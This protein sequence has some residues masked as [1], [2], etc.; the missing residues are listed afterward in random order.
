[1]RFASVPFVASAGLSNLNLTINGTA[2]TIA[3]N[4]SGAL[5]STPALPTGVSIVST[6]TSSAEGRVVIEYDPA[7]NTV[8]FNQPQDA[9]GMKTADLQLK[10]ENDRI[11]V[12]SLSGE[13]INVTATANSLNS[14]SIS[15]NDTAVEDLLVLPQGWGQDLLAECMTI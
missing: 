13:V 1:M 14:Q 4:S 7:V 5:A 10:L 15:I 6:V 11:S 9:L 2:H 3:M 8:L 12:A